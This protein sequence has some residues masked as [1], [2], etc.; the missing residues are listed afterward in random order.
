MLWLK[1]FFAEKFSEN[2][3]VFFAQATDS[4][5]KQFIIILVFEKNANFFSPK[6]GKNGRKLWS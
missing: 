4:F 3:G 6:I 1:Y 5:W 2:I